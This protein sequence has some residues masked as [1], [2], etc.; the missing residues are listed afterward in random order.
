MLDESKDGWYGLACWNGLSVEQQRWLLEW[1]S[2]PSGYEPAGCCSRGA[3]V[4]IEMV[5]DR[6]PGP[7]FYCMPCAFVYLLGHARAAA[8]RGSEGA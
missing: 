3:Q 8:E 1:G 4:A 2:L 7:R 6:A 5:D